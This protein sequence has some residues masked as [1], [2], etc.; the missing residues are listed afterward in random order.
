MALHEDV[1]GYIEKPF[2]IDDLA[3]KIIPKLSRH[4]KDTYPKGISVN[5]LLLLSEMAEKTG[6]LEIYYSGKKKGQFYLDKGV[7]S[8]AFCEDL[9]G[10]EAAIEMIRLD[11][12]SFKFKGL[13]RKNGKQ[14]ISKDPMSSFA[15]GARLKNKAIGDKEEAGL[16]VVAKPKKKRAKQEKESDP[17][18]ISKADDK[19]KKILIV[20]D[21]S[22]IRKL[23][24]TILSRK[25]YAV[26][27]AKNGLDAL[28]QLNNEMPD[29]VLLDIVMPRMDGYR[30]LSIMKES[31]TFKDIPVIIL[32]GRD[33]MLDKIRGKISGSSE[34]LTKPFN[35]D[36]LIDTISKYLK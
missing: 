26:V 11:C 9:N 10:M 21:N 19:R 5:S 13:A 6:L 2:D 1:I 34:Y 22:N 36:K 30:V 8:D 27:E 23:I 14:R 32:S 25:G 7:L 31:V 4:Y 12:V 15:K 29:L 35:P 33:A 17:S 24:V 16:A 3:W 28:S 20:D 18:K